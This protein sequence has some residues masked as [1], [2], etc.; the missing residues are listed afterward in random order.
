[1]V[2]RRNA[3]AFVNALLCIILL[4]MSG[5]G[6]KTAWQ[7]E[8]D[9]G[10]RYLSEGNYEEAVIAFTAAIQIDP[11]KAEAYVALADA[12]VDMGEAVQAKE[13]L[14]KALDVAGDDEALLD[15]I[16]EIEKDCA[17]DEVADGEITEETSAK[18][19]LDAQDASDEEMSTWRLLE[20][21]VFVDGSASDSYQMQYD[22]NEVYPSKVRRVSY[23][24]DG[25]VSTYSYDDNSRVVE[26]KEYWTSGEEETQYP[27]WVTN[28]EYDED[29]NVLK[30]IGDGYETVYSYEDG[31][32]V[33]AHTDGFAYEGLEEYYTADEAYSYDEQGLLSSI[34]QVFN[35]ETV[36]Y[37]SLTEYSYDADG[38]LIEEKYYTDGALQVD[39]TYTYDGYYRFS[40]EDH[41]ESGAYSCIERLDPVGHVLYSI[42]VEGTP[43]LI[44]D[45]NRLVRAV[46]GGDFL[47][48]IYEQIGEE[49]QEP[50]ND[51]WKKAYL[52]YI[53][54]DW[55]QLDYSQREVT[56]YNLI[57][58]TDG[59]IPQLWIDHGFWIDN[60]ICSFNG[61]SIDSLTV[62]Y[63]I[64]FAEGTGVFCNSG[65]RQGD[66]YDTLY[67]IDDTGIF[68]I[69]NGHYLEPFGYEG[70]AEYYWN[71]T[72]ISQEEYASNITA[73]F[74]TTDVRQPWQEY[75][76]NGIV[77]YLL[78]KEAPVDTDDSTLTFSGYY[79]EQIGSISPELSSLIN[80]D[81]MHQWCTFYLNTWEDW[82]ITEGPY[83]VDA[84]GIIE[85]KTEL[86]IDC[87]EGTVTEYTDQPI[88][89]FS[90]SE[91]KI[92]ILEK[93]TGYGS[94]FYR[95]GD[96]F[97]V[98]PESGMGTVTGNGVRVRSGPG[99]DYTVFTALDSGDRVS[100]LGS[101]NG[102][103]RIECT[104]HSGS[105][106]RGFMRSD[107]IVRD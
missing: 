64:D 49:Q 21:N 8:Y 104:D 103:Y 22:I 107:Y 36:S 5:C 96:G 78:T 75:D 77:N 105:V 62:N 34:K 89:H 12:Y 32:I 16:K 25:N 100:I 41:A 39:K 73:A 95:A 29:G 79:T 28:Y 38:L 65:G 83:S 106:F 98:T 3:V 20:V 93:V 6:A 4:A 17:L 59:T 13:V 91:D 23:S 31:K 42:Y 46:S 58:I 99:T 74:G 72:L 80:F 84:N 1:M 27:N 48:F 30:E 70:K 51:G 26:N 24:G 86:A 43:E 54:E 102:W 67:K 44:Y 71:D 69:A 61:N 63:S 9:L 66:Y 76:Y 55:R 14:T 97:S 40:L 18:P 85:Y 35:A 10:V 56:T 94:E 81:S 47:E 101:S 50:T 15:K 68:V 88:T 92:T 37:E 7:E 57:R 11:Q 90:I 52:D 82:I 33:S 60:I 87:F 53:V 45:G 2:L 19:A